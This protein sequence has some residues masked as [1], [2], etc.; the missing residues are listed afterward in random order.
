MEYISH[1]D[2]TSMLKNFAKETPK[3]LLKE[4]L[5]PVGK[6]D[7]DVNNDGKVDKT[8]KYLMKRRGA[9][10]KAMGKMD[11]MGDFSS[12]RARYPNNDGPFEGEMEEGPRD[13]DD[14]IPA[15]L[16]MYNSD[17]YVRAMQDAGEDG[18]ATR[19]G[20]F[21]DVVDD[22]DQY[23]D[24]S[25]SDYYDDDRDNMWEEDKM[26]EGG[27]RGNLYN[28]LVDKLKERGISRDHMNQSKFI[29]DVAKAMTAVGYSDREINNSINYDQDFLPDLMQATK[30][31][32]KIDT[33]DFDD[34]D[35]DDEKQYTY[36]NKRGSSSRSYDDYADSVGFEEGLNA[37]PFKATAGTVQNVKEQAPFGLSVL[38]PDE[39]KQLKEYISS[40]REIK[41]AIQ[42]LVGKAK[43]GKGMMEATW[44]GPKNSKFVEGMKRIIDNHFESYLDGNISYDILIHMLKK[45]VGT[46]V[47]SSGEMMEATAKEDEEV[48]A[49]RKPVYNE[50]SSKPKSKPGGNRTGLVMTKAEMWEG[51]AKNQ[52]LEKKVKD[53]M[54]K[55]KLTRREALEFIKAEKEHE[56][57]K[58]GEEAKMS[59]HD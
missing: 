46:L 25:S 34:H 41:K 12:V 44:G 5:D 55:D 31:S 26:E 35:T 23:T 9:I 57:E 30:Q 17:Q 8:D 7:D 54:V 53:L 49:A 38:S 22:E 1:S 27:Y 16:R 13:D 52:S 39:Q 3:G 58:K 28:D 32:V 47:K 37:P 4:A 6:E 36:S 10:G 45:I 50:P 18:Y 14:N 19:N 21:D 40:V 24:S 20:D 56:Q 42:E 33:G 2:Y 59:Q 51:K 11:E 43:N 48:P 29:N 15:Y